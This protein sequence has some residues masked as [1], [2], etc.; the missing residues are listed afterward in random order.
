M[1]QVSVIIPNYNHAR[2]LEKRIGSVL[3]QTYQD[4]E[5]ILLDD[6]STDDS[7]QV[8]EGYRNN[9]RVQIH[10]NESNSGS[11]F[12]QWNR[13]FAL[14]KGRYVWIAE[15]D[16]DAEPD[17]LAGLVSQLDQHAEAV[18]AYCASRM[19]DPEN[20]DLGVIPDPK[21]GGPHTRFSAPFNHPG[22]DELFL[23][24]TSVC[25]EI[26]NASGALFPMEVIRRVGP[27]DATYRL[28]GDWKFYSRI[29][30]SGGSVLFVPQPWNRFR[31]HPRSARE[32][33]TRSGKRWK[34][35][36]RFYR[37]MHG[38][39]TWNPVERTSIKRQIGEYVITNMRAMRAHVGAQV[40]GKT[41]ISLLLGDSWIRP[42]LAR[43]MI[44]QS[45]GR[46]GT[47]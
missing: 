32:Q 36:S 19:V 42:S 4:F 31:C 28:F 10:C 7:R 5:L 20:R 15:S 12:A 23:Q 11:P 16:D 37:E 40:V 8:F 1:P 22:R 30:L 46:F 3:G 47:R 44:R 39:P 14:A 21:R 18:V 25:N 2:F 43:A 9:P 38:L 45:L 17:L 26:P 41:L 27:A 24:L 33:H 6:A 35:L 29:L 13:G 34:E